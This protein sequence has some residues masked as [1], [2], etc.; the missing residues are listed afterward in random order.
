MLAVAGIVW[1][2]AS[3]AS[4]KYA[5]TFSQARLFGA[6]FAGSSLI[7]PFF[8]GT[9]AGAI[10]SGGVPA[11]GYGDRVGSWINATSLVGGCLAVTTCAFLAGVFLTADA[12]RAGIANL[13][14]RLR[15]PTLSVR[16]GNRL[17]LFPALSPLLLH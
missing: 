15:G 2:G 6:I 11:G 12:D 1:R 13:T 7:T 16:T 3:F 5:E 4:G 9:V 10:A 8:F 17:P 14:H